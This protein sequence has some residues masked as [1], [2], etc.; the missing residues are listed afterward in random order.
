MA[1]LLKDLL[2]TVLLPGTAAVYV[3]LRIAHGRPPASVWAVAL[4]L[5]AF[6]VGGAI[7]A[8][9]VCDFAS[10]GRGTPSPLDASKRLVVRGLFR[11]TRNPMYVGVLTVILGWA[12]LFQ[13]GILAGYALVVGIGFHLVV[14]L[15]EERHLHHAFGD[16]YDA[17]C[18]RVGRWLPRLDRRTA[19]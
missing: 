8:W 16:D 10:F 18:S 14:V 12:L 4:A 17:Y 13:T 11:H 2:F 7:Y 5:P 15:Y 3:P 6:A 9:C 19:A 1:L